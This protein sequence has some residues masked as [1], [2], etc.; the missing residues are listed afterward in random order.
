MCPT[1]S[2]RVTHNNSRSISKSPLLP[3]V[4]L[5]KPLDDIVCDLF[6]TVF[7]KFR[8][9]TC[10]AALDEYGPPFSG[11]KHKM[12]TT[13]SMCSPFGFVSI[14]K[15]AGGSISLLNCPQAQHMRPS[16]SAVRLGCYKKLP[17]VTLMS[18][19]LL[20]PSKIQ[21][22]SRN[23]LWVPSLPSILGPVKREI[24]TARLVPE[25]SH[26]LIKPKRKLRAQIPHRGLLGTKM[27]R[28]TGYVLLV[29]KVLK[30]HKK[31]AWGG[32]RDW[33]E[34][35]KHERYK[36]YAVDLMWLGSAVDVSGGLE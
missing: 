7:R 35:L 25:P 14:E 27:Q 12:H 20:I 28:S 11:I 8:P 4:R 24:D 31:G 2:A 3:G 30:A 17:I 19:L 22:A 16:L 1:S 33:A 23:P 18:C 21:K 34:I 15:R 26:N 10:D 29:G 9:K 32:F 5:K 36:A 6:G 13:V